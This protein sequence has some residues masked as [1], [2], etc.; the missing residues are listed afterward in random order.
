MN[1]EV[2]AL[3]LLLLYIFK[4]HCHRAGR[5]LYCKK[6]REKG[7]KLTKLFLFVFFYLGYRNFFFL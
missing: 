2:L 1:G 3:L 7:T 5:A 4:V 6:E